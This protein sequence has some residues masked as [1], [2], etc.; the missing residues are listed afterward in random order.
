VAADELAAVADLRHLLRF[1]GGTIRRRA[2]FIWAVGFLS[3]M[4]AAVAVVPA[5]LPGA[6]D[7]SRATEFSVLIPTAFAGFLAL[8]IVSSVV[9]GGGRELLP[10]DQAVAFPVSPTT[11]HLGALLLAPLNIAWLLQAWGLL[12]STAYAF[13]AESVYTSIPVGL[14]WIATATATAQAIAWTTEAVRRGPH[15]ILIVRGVAAALVILALALHFTGNLSAVL[16][17]LPTVWFVAGGSFG[18]SWRWALTLVVLVAMLAVAVALGAVPAH[19]AARR[20]PRDEQRLESES[21]PALP[22]PRSDLLA[23]V[24]TDRASI[25]RAVPMRRGML[26]LAVG[27]GIVAVAGALPWPTLTILPGLVA[28]GGALLFGVNIWCLDGRG[29]LWRESLPVGPGL[30]F[31]ARTLVLG[32]F[33]LLASAIT[34]ALGSL[35]AGV[36][37]ASELAALCCTWVV[38]TVQVVAAA[39]RWSDQRPYAVDLRSA[40]ATP[41]PAVLMVVYSARL[42]LST[43]M[44][45]L[46]FYFLA[47]A[48]DYRASLI[49]AVPFLCWSL[50]RMLRTRRAWTQPVNR[51]RIVT[52]VTV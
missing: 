48:P 22:S 1:R 37:T 21:R 40:R 36:P 26:V 31:A 49:V 8:T 9:S 24:R 14:L 29:S 10:R 6:G 47:N 19:L 32:E 7:S 33:L 35:R 4:T 20:L 11:D 3:V 39:M 27:P 50:A 16:D 52:T 5:Y 46:V 18:V 38:V 45:G 13:G 23:L 43:T 41:A 44:T 51:A 2:L 12:G 15:G 34:I 30:V 25:W 42:A 28:S 17:Q